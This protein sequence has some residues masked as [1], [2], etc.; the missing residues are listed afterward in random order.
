[1]RWISVSS[2]V[3]LRRRNYSGVIFLGAT[4]Q[5]ASRRTPEGPAAVEINTTEE[6]KKR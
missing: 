1:M 6:G 5:A 3:S 4:P 2:R